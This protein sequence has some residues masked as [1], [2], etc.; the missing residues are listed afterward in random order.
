MHFTDTFIRRPVFATVLSLIILLV[1]IRAFVDLPIRQYPIISPSVIQIETDYPGA[2]A[3][4]MEGFVTTP[5]ENAL[6]SVQGLDYMTSQS[7]QGESDITM[8]FQLNYDI[9]MA[10][11]DVSNAVNSVRSRLPVNIE[12]PIINKVDP[13][14]KPTLWLDFSSKTMNAEAITDY[15]E[16]VIQPQ[17]EILPGVSQAK[18]F[19]QREYAMRLWLDPNRMAARNLTPND[20]A[21]AL[22]NNNVLSA[23]GTLYSPWQTA[24][25]E[26]HTDLQTEKEFN[27]L[28]LNAKDGY[29]TRVSDVGHAE[30]GAKDVNSTSLNIN[31]DP[32]A[33]ALGIVPQPNADPI[34]ISAEVD[35]VLPNII[36]DLPPELTAH[37]IW[38]WSKFI[39]QSIHEVRSTIFEATVFVIIVIFLF[40]GSVRAVFIPVVTI[41]LSVIGIC[42]IML[43]L[44]YTLN[45][46]TLL[47]WVLAIGLVVDDSI[48]VAENIHRHIEEGKTPFNA[49]IIGAREIGFAIIAMTLTLASVYAPIGFMTDMTGILFREFAFTLAGAV[50]I[51]GFV[52]LTLS[53]MMCSKFLHHEVNKKGLVAKIDD[54]FRILVSKYKNT[55]HKLLTK[56][57]NVLIVAGIVYIAC[58]ALYMTLPHELA[59][60]EDQGAV[61]GMAIGPTSANL[62]YTEKYT[63]QMAEIYKTIPETAGYGFINGYDSQNDALTFLVLK[64]WEQRK[65]SS[66]DI[67]QELNGKFWN[68]SGVQAFAFN[69]PP[70]PSP[71]RTPISFILKTTGSYEDLNT[72]TEKLMQTIQKENPHIMNLQSDLKLDKADVIV[73]VDR[74]KANALGIDMNDVSTALNTLVAQPLA[75][76]FEISG[77]GYYVIPE[78]YPQYMYFAQQLNNINVRTASGELMP[79]SNIVTVKEAAAPQS[80]NHFQQMRAA[81]ITAMPA[82][83]YTLGQALDYMTNLSKQILPKEMQVDYSQQSRQFT[84]AS[85]SMGGTFLFAVIFIFLVLA[86]QFE[87]FRDPLIVMISVP[88]SLTGALLAIHFAGGSINIYTQI[89]LVTLIGLISKHGI[90]IVE[91]ANQMQHR[92]MNIKEAVIEAASLRLRPILMTTGAMIFG[93]LPLA[94]ASGAGA[95]ARRQLG[96]V[97]IGGMSFGTLLTLF[98]VPAVYTYLATRKAVETANKELTS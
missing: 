57:K 88:L 71:G 53:P 78:L 62:A 98:I 64:P 4:L 8:Q 74:N 46:L 40:L 7:T 79:L 43:V 24:N 26:A 91:F 3:Q 36:A 2:S 86:A 55:L 76:Q 73:T 25:I 19:G 77:R 21:T 30:L 85:G 32:Q 11:A 16:R 44:G 59:P 37:V 29:L 63:T 6:G 68:I 42:G 12:D 95:E 49:A 51:S 17:M 52:A 66:D 89:G 81:T 60:N 80:L 47:A 67:I 69:L 92:G 34:G 35:K 20:V 97:V 45:T 10:M 22:N 96:M 13:S 31:G 83:G 75:S 65:R 1:G 9:T 70:L 28:V 90:L 50:L 39:K 38:D 5:L 15:L 41:P 82:P 14:A 87:S 93:A 27:K 23:P 48:V 61:L 33:V 54:I 94:M 84:Q 56:R 18:I 58:V 72:A